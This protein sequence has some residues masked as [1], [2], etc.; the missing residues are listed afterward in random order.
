MPEPSP[1][2]SRPFYDSTAPYDTIGRRAQYDRAFA[3]NI[4]HK[5]VSS[6]P[7]SATGGTRVLTH[8]ESLY[9]CR[10]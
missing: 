3:L 8:S 5:G 10:R 1:C 6:A 2:S 4:V 7:C 9:F